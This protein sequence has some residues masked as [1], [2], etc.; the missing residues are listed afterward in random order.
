MS[1][2]YNAV[3]HTIRFFI[4]EF[5]ICLDCRRFICAFTLIYLSHTSVEEEGII[6]DSGVKSTSHFFTLAHELLDLL[7]ASPNKFS[8]HNCLDMDDSF[9]HDSSVSVDFLGELAKHVALVFNRNAATP[10][11]GQLMA[12]LVQGWVV[13]FVGLFADASATRCH[14]VACT[15]GSHPDSILL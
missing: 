13:D 1:G 12:V 2:I 14:R 10:A 5:L 6:A 8:A 4:H 3:L 11:G 9:E 7:H 15:L